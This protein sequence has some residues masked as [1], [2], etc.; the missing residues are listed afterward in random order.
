MKYLHHLH[1]NWS[2]GQPWSLI[3]DC[4]TAH[5]TPKVIQLAGKLKIQLIYVPAN[6]TSIYQ[7]LDRK[8][9]GILKSKMKSFAKS[10]IYSGKERFHIIIEYLKRAWK[11]ISINTDALESALDIPGLKERIEKL[12]K[13][14]NEEEE[15]ESYEDVHPIDVQPD[16]FLFEYSRR[17]G[18]N[19]EDIR[20]DEYFKE[21]EEKADILFEELD[22]FYNHL[23]VKIYLMLQQ[24]HIYL[25]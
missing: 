10:C 25:K 3:M 7:P 13:H 1:D 21:E 6:G 17:R 16:A 12:S 14:T 9:F 11:E 4:Y 18:I 24:I 19:F 23:L 8:A 20:F 2:Y 15:E 22:V 5:H